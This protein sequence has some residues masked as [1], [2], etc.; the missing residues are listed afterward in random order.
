MGRKQIMRRAVGR[1]E[2]LGVP[3]VMW[4]HNLPP[5]VEIGLTDVPKSGG[6]M[7]SPA[8]PGTTGLHGCYT[9]CA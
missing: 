2:N 8:P 4:G 9:E 3:V 5:L 6:A 7:A 1:S